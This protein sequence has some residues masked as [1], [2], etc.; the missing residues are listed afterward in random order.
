MS[1]V[2]DFFNLYLDEL[3]D[4][5]DPRERVQRSYEHVKQCLTCE[6]LLKI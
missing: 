4:V 2:Q 5:D 6:N 1:L 3:Y